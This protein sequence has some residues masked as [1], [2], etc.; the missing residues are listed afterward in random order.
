MWSLDDI[1]RQNNEAAVQWL[2]KG[3][4]ARVARFPHLD[5]WPLTL[6][7]EQ[8]R[9]GPPNLEDLIDLLTD[10]EGT[11]RFDALVI[12]FLP[13]YIDEILAKP[14]NKR[15]HQFCVRFAKK[16]YPLPLYVYGSNIESFSYSL[17]VDIMGLSFLSY[18]EMGHRPGYQLLMALVVYPW[19][20]D[21]YDGYLEDREIHG[22]RTAL[23]QYVRENI[24]METAR[25]IYK[26]GWL[27][28]ELHQ[29]TDGT[30]YDGC[31]HFADWVCQCTGCIILDYNYNKC[32][33]DEGD[34]EPNFAWSQYN[35]ETLATQYKKT[36]EIL[37]KI[38]HIV[39][40]IEK[41]LQGRFRALVNHL[42]TSYKPD[43]DRPQFIGNDKNEF[44]PLEQVGLEDEEDEEDE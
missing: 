12:K 17:P 39:E 43:K 15:V 19:D 10:K 14:K 21:Y 42:H 31:G 18:L 7:S 35:V 13:E 30:A 36:H 5:T 1:V 26:N 16:Y 6:R 2:E 8:M 24:G 27:P 40:Y 29:M 33:Y 44:I 28:Q 32:Q 25:K 37:Q 41:D 9:R 38:D 20:N 22:D 11:S 4:Q 3:E 23:V 34:T